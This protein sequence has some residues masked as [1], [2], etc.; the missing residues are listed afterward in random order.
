[1]ADEGLIVSLD[2]FAELAGVTPETMRTHLKDMLREAAA[3]PAW[4]VERGDRGRAYKI[5]AE[6]G[7]RWW[8]D[9]READLLADETRRGKL[10]QLRLDVL[11]PAAEQPDSLSLSGRQRRDEYAAAMDAVRYRKILG[12]LVEKVDIERVL[13]AASVEHRRR[14]Q[15]IA[16][17]FGI[18]AG[19]EPD[20]VRKLDA[21]IERAVDSFVTTITAPDAF[22]SER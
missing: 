14:L 13:S 2:E 6:G 12:E 22:A 18:V 1:M 8:Q 10:Q 16:P 4:L 7:L 17:E 9:K 5:E 19:L 21:M 20:Q 15:Q 11:G 3:E